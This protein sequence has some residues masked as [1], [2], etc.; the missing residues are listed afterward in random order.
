MRLGIPQRHRRSGNATEKLTSACIHPLAGLPARDYA[1]SRGKSIATRLARSANWNTSDMIIIREEQAADVEAVRTVNLAAFEGA[2]EAQIVDSL[3]ANG[4]VLL[5]LVALVED[6]LVGHLLLSPLTVGSLTG[7][8]LGPMAVSP[9]YQRQGIG[10]A[11]VTRAVGLLRNRDC[12]F[13]VVIGHPAFYPRFGFQPAASFGLTCE[14][15]V[16]ADMF[17]VAVLSDAVTDRLIGCA[18]YR[19]EFSLSA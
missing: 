16:P 9:A 5:S 13:V 7:A 3:R 15:P 18:E 4:G 1:A 19:P 6:H 12:P 17:M 11:L 14:W 2:Q 10:S 8:A